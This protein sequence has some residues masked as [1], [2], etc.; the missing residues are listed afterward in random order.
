[1]FRLSYPNSEKLDDT[2]QEG[3]LFWKQHTF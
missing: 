3:K 2:I 1:M